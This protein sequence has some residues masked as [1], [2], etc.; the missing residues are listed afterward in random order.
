MDRDTQVRFAA[1]DWLAQQTA[2]HGDV[3]PWSLL[4]EGFR[5]E[6]RRVPLLS[7]QGIFKPAAL[8]EMPLSIRTSH[9]G[10]YDDAFTDD[11]LILYKYRGTDPD[12]RDNVSLRRAY[13]AD[14]PLIYLHGV[15]PAKYLVRWPV[16][17][18][19]DDPAR[20]TFTV[21]LDDIALGVRDRVDRSPQET[22][23]RRQYATATIRKRLHQEAFRG[24]V[25]AAYREQCATCRLRH[26]ELLDAA[27][28][29]ADREERGEPRVKNGLAL[30]KIHHAAFDRHIVGVQP[31]Y[32]L[33][34]ID[35]PMLRHG[36]QELH[37]K[38]LA[39]P[40]RH[41]H[42]PD[43]SLLEMRFEEFRRAG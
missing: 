25:I 12:H 23:I 6:G 10:P 4:L 24:R 26:D 34:E 1:F 30:C 32:I 41:E 3:L 8:P 27:H 28:L 39:V 7:Q 20:L 35:G 29:I 42:Q 14:K 16:R 38:R 21:A 43:P 5:F 37:D 13:E 22:L 11:D 36:L 18:V 9:E 40:R 2:L 19:A 31:D 33:R 17:V 15:M